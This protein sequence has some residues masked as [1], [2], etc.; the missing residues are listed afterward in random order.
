MRAS[1]QTCTNMAQNVNNNHDGQ[2][3]CPLQQNSRRR[4]NDASRRRGKVSTD[5]ESDEKVKLELK[6]KCNSNY[7]EHFFTGKS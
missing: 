4:R 6:N 2:E 1:P 7:M 5:S 3:L